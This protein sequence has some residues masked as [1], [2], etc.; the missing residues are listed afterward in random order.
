MKTKQFL[1]IF[2]LILLSA[3]SSKAFENDPQSICLRPGTN[4]LYIGGEFNY[5][6]VIDASTGA[7]IRQLSI[8]K[9]ALAVAF[10]KNADK[11]IITESNKV[12][13]LDPATGE[14][15]QSM[16]LDDPYV[17]E[18][19]PYIVSIKSFWDKAVTLHSLED[20]SPISTFSFDFEPLHVGFNESFTELIVLG[21]EAD[22]EEENKLIKQEVQETEGY[23]VYVKTFVEQQADG[24]GSRFKVI[25]IASE[26]TKLDVVI[27]YTTAK[28]YSLLISKYAESYYV[29]GFDIFI[30]IDAAGSA[31]PIL[32]SNSGFSY[33]SGCSK[34]GKTIYSGSMNSLCMYDCSTAK[35]FEM[36]M[37]ETDA[38][39]A[40]E[41]FITA[42]KVYL[43]NEDLN[44]HI[45]ST[46]GVK[47]K[48]VVAEV[49]SADGFAVYYYNGYVKKEKRDEEAA[50]INAALKS[51]GLGTI[52]L[53]SAIGESKFLVAVF[54]S[55]KEA[56]EFVESIDNEVDYSLEVLP[57]KKN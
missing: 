28:T 36:Q 31:Y 35:Y 16:D 54:Q 22:I 5:L 46:K 45:C 43:L 13:W 33:A 20:G 14:I 19:S 39:Y 42:D 23:D 26:T 50:P 41:F 47:S 18:G 49:V 34:D 30:K 56:L 21:N 24:K 40:Q 12:H 51:K 55:K 44:V 37:G 32:V 11:L 15:L 6:M 8:P 17:K 25:D 4:E 57:Y 53:E 9:E 3:F 38:A 48:T 10:N 1:S 7:S 2:F 27:P 29:L 52:D